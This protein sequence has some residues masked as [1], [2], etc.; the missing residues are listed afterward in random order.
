[1]STDDGVLVIG[2]AIGGTPYE[3]SI[4]AEYKDGSWSSIGNLAR[5]RRYHK[6]IKSGS[7][8]MILGGKEEDAST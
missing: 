3:T 7:D 2:G 4:V 6:A 1:M 5:V 8:I